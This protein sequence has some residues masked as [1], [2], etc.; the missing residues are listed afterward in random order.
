MET[1]QTIDIRKL[2]SDIIEI[3]KNQKWLKNQRK[4]VHK[5]CSKKEGDPEDIA[6]WVATSIH[7]GNKEMLRAMFAAYG[8]ARGRKYSQTENHYPEE[9]H[10]LHQLQWRIDKILAK[11][12]VEV[13][14][15]E[16]SDD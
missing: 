1:T 6:P 11:Y 8:L 3:S 4:T 15:D 5:D 2:K 12:K 13:E 10:P 9:G 16:E 14:E 7:Q